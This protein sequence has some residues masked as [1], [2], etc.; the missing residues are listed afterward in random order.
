MEK[1]LFFQDRR[2]ALV[3]SLDR[4]YPRHSFQNVIQRHALVCVDAA[5]PNQPKSY[6]MK[7]GMKLGGVQRRWITAICDSL[8][9]NNSSGSLDDDYHDAVHNAING[10]TDALME[11]LMDGATH[12]WATIGEPIEHVH[13]NLSQKARRNANKTRQLLKTYVGE[14]HRMY[15]TRNEESYYVAARRTLAAANLLGSW[16]DSIA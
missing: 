2:A 4:V 5:L 10:G 1:Q 11:S 14:L 12:D 9:L 16:L 7:Q 15:Q 13:R 8:P 6:Y 3:K